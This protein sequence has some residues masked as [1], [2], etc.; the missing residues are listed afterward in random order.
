MGLTSWG[1]L[2]STALKK[3]SMTSLSTSMPTEER[4]FSTCF[5]VGAS[6]PDKTTIRYA[7]TYFIAMVNNEERKTRGSGTHEESERRTWRL[8]VRKRLA[9]HFNH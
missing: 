8:T 4:V 1:D 5:F 9:N 7:A 6:V 2:P 3:A